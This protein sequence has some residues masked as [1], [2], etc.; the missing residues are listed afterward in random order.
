[1]ISIDFTFDEMRKFLSN[2]GKYEIEVIVLNDSKIE[3][4]YPKDIPLENFKHG[5][6]YHQL[7]EWKILPVFK[8]E[9]KNKILNL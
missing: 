1:M 4:A 6:D 2:T 9:L 7:I 3:I 8:R 5:K